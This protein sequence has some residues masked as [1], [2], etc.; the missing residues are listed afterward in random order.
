VVFSAALS[1]HG[2]AWPFH[3]MGKSLSKWKRYDGLW[4]TMTV[5]CMNDY[6]LEDSWHVLLFKNSFW[7]LEKETNM[8]MSH[9]ISWTSDSVVSAVALKQIEHTYHMTIVWQH[10]YRMQPSWPVSRG[11]G[12]RC[13]TY[14]WIPKIW[15][16]HCSSIKTNPN[17]MLPVHCTFSAEQQSANPYIRLLSLCDVALCFGPG[18]FLPGTAWK[19]YVSTTLWGQSFLL[20]DL[21]FQTCFSSSLLGQ[22]SPLRPIILG[23]KLPAVIVV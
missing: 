17:K 7:C 8:T 14:R 4:R 18:C 10:K 3:G 6:M 21:C 19:C 1:S 20:R 22:V 2:L 11:K 23:W 9:P 5:W 16:M 13:F 12:T 15:L